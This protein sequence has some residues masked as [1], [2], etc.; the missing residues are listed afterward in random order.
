MG[1]K[2]Y[3]AQMNFSRIS[4]SRRK[5]QKFLIEKFSGGKLERE[6]RLYAL[7]YTQLKIYPTNI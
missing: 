7:P 6:L 2:R 4:R 5:Y 1:K 3:S